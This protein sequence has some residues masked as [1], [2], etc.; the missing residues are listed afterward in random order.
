MGDPGSIP[1]S[2]RSP[3]ELHG[4]PLQYPCLKNSMDRGA[5]WATVHGVSRVRH[6]WETKAFTFTP[7]SW[8]RLFSGLNHS[9]TSPPAQ[10]VSFFFF[11]FFFWNIDTI[12]LLNI[13][14]S[15]P[16]TYKSNNVKIMTKWKCLFFVFGNIWNITYYIHSLKEKNYQIMSIWCTLTYAVNFNLIHIFIFFNLI[17]FLN[18]IILY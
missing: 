12:N 2:G 4:N 5:W 1:G 3:G 15:N 14:K 17:L 6:D 9:S 16:A 13:R 7:W 8:L 11:F 18:F 10:T